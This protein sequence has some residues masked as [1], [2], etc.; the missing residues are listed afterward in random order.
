MS[1]TAPKG[2]YVYQPHSPQTRKDGRL[3]RIG[4]LPEDLTR[5]EAEAVADAINEICWMGRECAECGHIGRFESDR[6]SSCSA[7]RCAPWAT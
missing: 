3:W 5:D 6:C 2:I 7:R 1:E 4:G